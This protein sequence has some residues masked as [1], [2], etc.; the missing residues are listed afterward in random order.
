MLLSHAL[1]YHIWSLWFI[2]G[3]HLQL[4]AGCELDHLG[5][6]CFTDLALEFGKVVGDSDVVEL[7]LNFAVD[8]VLET[9]NMNE[10]ASALALARTDQRILLG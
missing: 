4:L 10:L 3:N 9:A 7:S 2:E 6:K 1:E 5:E 8:P